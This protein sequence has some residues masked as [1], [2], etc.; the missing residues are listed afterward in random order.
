MK[1]EISKKNFWALAKYCGINRKTALE[2]FSNIQDDYGVKNNL[3]TTRIK[4][5]KLNAIMNPNSKYYDDS[6]KLT[7]SLS[8]MFYTHQRKLSRFAHKRITDSDRQWVLLSQIKQD[9]VERVAS[10]DVSFHVFAARLILEAEKMS[11]EFGKN[12]LYLSFLVS[13]IEELMDIT[14]AVLKSVVR[15]KEQKVWRSYRIH[16][17]AI[18]GEHL[19]PK[20]NAGSQDHNFIKDILV[21][22]KDRGISSKLFMSIQFDAFGVFNSFPTLKNLITS[23][24]IDRME[25]GLLKRKKE[26]GEPLSAEERKYWKDIKNKTAR[27]HRR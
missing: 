3:S 20:L 6:P 24:A 8:L 5:P 11:N 4:K 13:R 27:K 9:I 7:S 12:N 16:R 26:R 14:G 19:Y 18:T 23:K 25:Q 1:F 22:I 2:L 15:E 17:E 21:I 10:T